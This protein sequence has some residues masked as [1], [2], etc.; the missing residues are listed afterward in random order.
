MVAG[1]LEMSRFQ[2]S[3]N[4]SVRSQL[5]SYFDGIKHVHHNGRTLVEDLLDCDPYLRAHLRKCDAP[6]RVG[7]FDRKTT[8]HGCIATHYQILYQK[9]AHAMADPLSNFPSV[10]CRHHEKLCTSNVDQMLFRTFW[11]RWR[12]LTLKQLWCLAYINDMVS[13]LFPFNVPSILK[14]SY[15]T[16][17]KILCVNLCKRK[18]ID[19]R[20]VLNPY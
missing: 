6:L 3:F 16:E 5:R 10:A 1:K 19:W 18:R 20:I 2:S 7:T 9:K 15:D 14:L 8:R 11:P 13:V 12:S 4:I 17:N